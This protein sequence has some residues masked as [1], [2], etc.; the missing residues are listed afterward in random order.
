V[1]LNTKIFTNYKPNEI[2]NILRKVCEKF[3]YIFKMSERKYKGKIMIL[4]EDKKGKL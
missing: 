4:E 1:S 3:N 2:V